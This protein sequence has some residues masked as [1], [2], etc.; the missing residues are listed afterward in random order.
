[1]E[2]HLAALLEQSGAV[3]E[4]VLDVHIRQGVA[5]V[6]GVEIAV[7]HDDELLD[8]RRNL[9]LSVGDVVENLPQVFEFTRN[10]RYC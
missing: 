8:A 5:D 9:Y 10:G 3:R 4:H 7:G 1:M 6:L 2:E